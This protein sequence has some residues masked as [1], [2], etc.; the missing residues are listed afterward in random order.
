MHSHPRFWH[1][2]Q[3]SVRGVQ[4]TLDGTSRTPHPMYKDQ[5]GCLL[6]VH[7]CGM[8]GDW[9]QLTIPAHRRLGTHGDT[10]PRVTQLHGAD[11]PGSCFSC[12]HIA[13]RRLAQCGAV[14]LPARTCLACSLLSVPQD[15]LFTQ[16]L[17]RPELCSLLSC[18]CEC[19][20]MGT[21]RGGAWV[22]S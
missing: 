22:T 12:N 6:S 18:V 15:N 17:D 21:P 20:P 7:G 1:A 19:A 14:H 5:R 13:L 16:H 3:R 8:A 2:G 11:C 4:L 10:E 9:S